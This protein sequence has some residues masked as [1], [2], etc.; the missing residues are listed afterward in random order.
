VAFVR[1]S[2]AGPRASTAVVVDLES[3]QERIALDGAVL[4]AWAP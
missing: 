3:G 2:A 1:S 4:L